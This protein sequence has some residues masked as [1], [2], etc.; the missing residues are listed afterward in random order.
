M[1]K[2]ILFLLVGIACLSA[3]LY[4]LEPEPA[5]GAPFDD[6]FVEYREPIPP[7]TGP[8][9]INGMPGDLIWRA[10]KG[11][12]VYGRDGKFVF[13]RSVKRVWVDVG[14]NMLQTSRYELFTDESLG[15]IA[16][17]PLESCWNKWPKMERLI[18]IP[19]ALNNTEGPQTFY[20]TKFDQ[21]SSLLKSSPG[22]FLKERRQVQEEVRVE[23]FHLKRILEMIP[24]RLPIELLKV[25]VQGKDLEVLQ[26]AAAQLPRVRKIKTEVILTPLYIGDRGDLADPQQPFAEFLSRC[27]F[28]PAARQEVQY[29][30]PGTGKH[31]K[32]YA[33]VVFENE[34]CTSK[35]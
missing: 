16:V 10:N 6:R 12:P 27:G 28:K 1:N 14:A 22:E 33:D 8:S 17:E 13:P 35:E 23:V 15:V 11:R 18:A 19:F 31:T 21:W 7:Y 26:S 25:D 20:I 2:R 30:D 3:V 5:P 24:E 32:Y 9:R 4:R 34:R 29:A